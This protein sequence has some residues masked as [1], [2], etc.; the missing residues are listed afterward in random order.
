M[1]VISLI[2]CL[3]AV[4]AALAQNRPHADH[5]GSKI[6]HHAQHRPTAQ[7]HTR[8]VQASRKACM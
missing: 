1:K 5:A 8:K 7:P 4:N 2:F 3:F 6:L